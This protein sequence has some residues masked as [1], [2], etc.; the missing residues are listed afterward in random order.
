MTNEELQEHIRLVYKR[1]NR[2]YYLW[3]KLQVLEQAN[4]E[5]EE[6]E[7]EETEEEEEEQEQE[8]EQEQE[9]RPINNFF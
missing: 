2:I 5:E 4:K 8:Q 9:P 7:P 1:N 3:K 6:E